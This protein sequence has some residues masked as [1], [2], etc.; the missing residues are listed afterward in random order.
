[1]RSLISLIAAAAVL[2][3]GAC[4][5]EAGSR[6]LGGSSIRGLFPGTFEAQVDGYRVQF[7]GFKN[8]TL[9]GESYGRLH[10]GRWF[11]KADELCVAWTQWTK[12]QAK[13][14][15]ISQQSGWFVASSAWGEMLKFRRALVAQQ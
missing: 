4:G 13:C 10:R 5:V 6:G 9:K 8:G 7:T 1:M 3:L 15:A 12:G 11:V 14:G 2:G